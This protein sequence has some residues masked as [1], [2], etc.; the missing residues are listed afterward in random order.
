MIRKL[1]ESSDRN[2]HIEYVKSSLMS[3][4][5]YDNDADD[6]IEQLEFMGFS[7]GQSKTFANGGEYE[8]SVYYDEVKARD[9]LPGNLSVFFTYSN[10][11]NR[12]E[13]IEIKEVQDDYSLKTV[14][15]IKLSKYES[16]RRNK[17]R[18][19]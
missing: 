4:L 5:R 14:D 6:I 12:V 9:M 15:S 8:T 13:K 1:S 18:R 3:T 16:V 11:D 7:K 17:R 2:S 10:F 19:K